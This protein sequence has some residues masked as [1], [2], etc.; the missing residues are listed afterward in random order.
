MS[1]INFIKKYEKAD[2]AKKIDL[3]CKHYHNFVK[4]IDGYAEGLCYVIY[5][6][7]ISKHKSDIY[8]LGVRVQTSGMHSDVTA[9]TA[10]SKVEIKRAVISCDFS[11]NEL[12]GLAKK[13]LYRKKAYLLRN[14][15]ADYELFNKQ[16]NVLEDDESRIFLGYINKKLTLYDIADE[17]GIQPESAMKRVIRIKRRLKDHM[18]LFFEGTI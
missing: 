2:A 1:E 3:I 15:R 6:D 12:E 7:R 16:L 14:M 4:I 9:D 10:I 17:K 13:E 18:L 5:N 8:E 11:G